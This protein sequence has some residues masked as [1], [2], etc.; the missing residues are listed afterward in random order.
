[1]A[2]SLLK[3]YKKK[4]TSLTLVPSEG[5]CFE[6]KKEGQLIFSKLKENRFPEIT[7][8]IKALA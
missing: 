1:L 3:T 5:G 6:V 8:I 7:E 4:I 2:D